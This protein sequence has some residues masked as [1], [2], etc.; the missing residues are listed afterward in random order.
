L[1]LDTSALSAM[2]DGDSGLEP[3]LQQAREIAIP[4][5]VLGEYRFGVKRSRKRESYEQWLE[6][7]ISTIRV[8]PVDSTA[9]ICYSEIRDELKTPGRPIPGNDLWVAAIV[10][11]HRLPLLSRDTHFDSVPGIRRISW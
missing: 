2:A 9:A 11:D 8:L 6:E 10:R 7:L 5:I 4:A 1:I 3:V